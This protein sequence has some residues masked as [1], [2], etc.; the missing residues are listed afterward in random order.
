MLGSALWRDD[1]I[2]LCSE[3]ESGESTQQPAAE[4]VSHRHREQYI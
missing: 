2:K 4:R 1:K 3:P